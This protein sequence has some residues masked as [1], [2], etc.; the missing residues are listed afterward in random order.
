MEHEKFWGIVSWSEGPVFYQEINL[1]CWGKGP[2][3]NLQTSRLPPKMW[4][5]NQ[6]F[7]ADWKQ[8]DCPKGEK[9]RDALLFMRSGE[10][11]EQC[12]VNWGTSW[13]WGLE[14][15]SLPLKSEKVLSL[16]AK[17][18]EPCFQEKTVLGCDWTSLSCGKSSSGLCWKGILTEWPHRTKGVKGHSPVWCCW[19]L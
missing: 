6:G 8:G 4:K 2:R 9:F 17:N 18:V 12:G 14:P 3:G 19:K 16:L 13:K 11:R 1:V 15:E 7:S 10:R 5:R